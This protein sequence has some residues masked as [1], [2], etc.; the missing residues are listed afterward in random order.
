MTGLQKN[1]AIGGGL[2]IVATIGIVLYKKRKDKKALEFYTKVD[3]SFGGTGL[4]DPK[5]LWDQA[6]STWDVSECR[7]TSVK[8]LSEPE[9]TALAT[10]YHDSFGYLWNDY[11]KI[12]SIVNQLESRYQ[13]KQVFDA[14]ESKY[15]ESGIVYGYKWSVGTFGGFGVEPYFNSILK[16]PRVTCTGGRNFSGFEEVFDYN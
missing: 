1:I 4:P 8:A 13:T 3:Q 12:Q 15:N 10:K 14:F 11:G 5:A 7:N 9:A 6:L 2:L 16:K